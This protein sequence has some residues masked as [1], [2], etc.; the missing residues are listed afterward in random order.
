MKSD[1]RN[2]RDRSKPSVFRSS[3]DRLAMLGEIE[4]DARDPFLPGSV[5]S[6]IRNTHFLYFAASTS[7]I[8]VRSIHIMNGHKINL[9]DSF[10][11][12]S[13]LF[14]SI[15]SGRRLFSRRLI[16]KF[17]VCERGLWLNPFPAPWEMIHDCSWNRFWKNELVVSLVHAKVFVQIPADQ[18]EAFETAI[19]KHGK[20]Y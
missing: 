11:F 6:L 5:L 19:R 14:I 9:V 17:A 16:P 20:M 1:E 13:M 15:V 2:S 12:V 3:T 10:G 4:L 8:V 7:W 18:A